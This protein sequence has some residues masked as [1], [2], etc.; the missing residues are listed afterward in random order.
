[1]NSTCQ[2]TFDLR[3]R[4]SL[5]PFVYLPNELI[6]FEIVWPCII[7]FGFTGNVMFIWTVRHT[8]SLHTSTFLFL[9]S[10]AITDSCVL[11]S[12]GLDFILD[13]LMTPIRHGD[14]FII[15]IM[16]FFTTWFCFMSSLFFV[17]LVSI[18]RYLAICHPIKH[19]LLKGTKRTIKL[20]STFFAVTCIFSSA[21]FY[22][23]IKNLYL[24]AIGGQI[25]QRFSTS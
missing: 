22:C 7:L 18:E 2:L 14:K 16:C 9:A 23:S 12:V 20:I 1:M 3:N 21:S 19:H 11:I 4:S 5:L 10:L 8:P 6:L 25:Y 24:T 13:F 17:T 15:K